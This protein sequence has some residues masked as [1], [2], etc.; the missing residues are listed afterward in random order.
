VTFNIEEMKL[1]AFE[2]VKATT[3]ERFYYTWILKTAEPRRLQCVDIFSYR[4][5]EAGK[6][7]LHVHSEGKSVFWGGYRIDNFEK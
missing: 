5:T 1:T 3:I 2:Y 6:T 4:W 7:Y